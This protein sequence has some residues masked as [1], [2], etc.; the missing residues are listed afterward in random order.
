VQPAGGSSIRIG[1]RGAT[2]LQPGASVR[3]TNPGDR[4]A[5]LL[6]FTVAPSTSG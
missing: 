5:R 3:V 1:P 2:T 4:P 6:K